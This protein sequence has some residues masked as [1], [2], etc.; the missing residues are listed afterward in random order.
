MNQAIS[1]EI[2]HGIELRL[3]LSGRTHTRIVLVIVDYFSKYCVAKAIPNKEA[4]TVIKILVRKRNLTNK[5][6]FAKLSERWKEGYIIKQ[7]ADEANA[8]IVEYDFPTG[9][10]EKKVNIKNIKKLVKVPD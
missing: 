9:K 1:P 3:D 4:E 10:K 7:K 6:E 8:Y 5:D 2:R